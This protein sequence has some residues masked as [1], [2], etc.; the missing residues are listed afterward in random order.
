MNHRIPVKLHRRVALIHTEDAVLA[1]ELLASKKLAPD[2]VRRLAE[3]DPACVQLLALIGR[4]RQPYWRVGNLVELLV[5]L[6]HADGLRPVLA[7]LEAGLL[8]PEY[9]AKTKLKRFDLWLSQAS[10]HYP[11]VV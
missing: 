3:I 9:V 4:S 2:I 8:F 5:A 6:G 7:L 10:G 1:E 11:V